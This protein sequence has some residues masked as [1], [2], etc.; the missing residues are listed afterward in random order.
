MS[1]HE[2]S[3]P[4][5]LDRLLHQP[6]RTRIVAYLA[7]RDEAS[8]TEIKKALGLTDGNLEAHMKKLVA[9][10]YIQPHKLDDSPRSQ[11]IYALTETGRAAFQGYVEALEQLIA[12]SGLPG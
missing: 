3:Q 4:A 12:L 8:F 11:T 5:Q 9:A 2:Q 1:I 7:G 6:V 10:E